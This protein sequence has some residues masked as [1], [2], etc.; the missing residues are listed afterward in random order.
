MGIKFGREYKDIV[1]DFVRGIAMVNGFYELLE[2]S[3]DDWE[4][5]EPEEQEECLRTLA[6]DIFYGLGN[7][8]VMHVGAGSVRHDPS[9]HVLKVHDGEKLVSVIYLV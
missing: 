8:P 4:E 2:M 6:D 9:N 5:L 1:T 7:S 3:A